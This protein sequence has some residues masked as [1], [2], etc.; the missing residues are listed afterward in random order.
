[1]LGG[2]KHESKH[3]R[4]TYIRIHIYVECF[5]EKTIEVQGC[6]VPSGVPDQ[7]MSD[8]APLAILILRQL[9]VFHT[10]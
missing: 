9:T 8:G 10:N 5:P 2:A 1:M 6:S 4:T 7:P 3:K